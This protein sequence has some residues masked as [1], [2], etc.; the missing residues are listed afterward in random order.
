LDAGIDHP[1]DADVDDRD[2]VP[3][4]PTAAW[5]GGG[6]VWSDRG[7]TTWAIEIAATPCH[8]GPPFSRT[9]AGLVD[10]TFPSRRSS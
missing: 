10:V 1:A 2:G 3:G 8:P 4:D 6:E 5:I 7:Q 9:L